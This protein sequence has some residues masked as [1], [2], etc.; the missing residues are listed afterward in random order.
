MSVRN[1]TFDHILPNVHDWP[2]YKI[3]HNRS[4]F[5]QELNEFILEH[6]RDCTFTQL[7]E[8]MTKT[9]YLEK[10]RIKLNPWKVDPADENNYW[11][12]I[13]KELD[14]IKNLPDRDEHGKNL[15]KKII[16]RYN[17]EIV[18][19]FSPRTFLFIRIFLL[20][21]FKRI[22]LRYFG[23]GRWRWGKKSDL[24]EKIKIK[25]NVELIRSL[26]DKG[27]VVVLPTHYSNLDSIMVG[28]A[29]DLNVGLPSF[30][31]GAG[32]NLFNYEIPA[33]FMSRLGAFKVDRRKK[34]P[35]YLECL[36][37]MTTFSLLNGVNCIFFPGG[38]RSRNGA[39]E[40]KL[41]LGL[42]GSL[43]DAQRIMLENN[44]DKKVFVVPLSISYNFVLEGSSL[45]DQHLQL[46]GRENYLRS[47]RRGPVASSIFR[48]LKELYTQESDVYMSFGDPMDVLGNRVD[49][50]GSSIDKKGQAVAVSD[51]FSLEGTIDANAQRESVYA[52]ILGESITE[53]YLH[54][55][56]IL[57]SNV[58]AY[59]AFRCIMDE[60]KETDIISLLSL[61]KQ[62]FIIEEST[63]I[64]QISDI[65]R[66]VKKLAEM[67]YCKLS[68]ENW[69]DMDVIL[70]SGLKK[71]GIYHYTTVLTKTKHA[72]IQC[73]DIKLLYF[74]HNRLVRYNL[75]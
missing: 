41:K 66:Q 20:S 33:F 58:V 23:K 65:V 46:V 75:K 55:T 9:A 64:H 51:Y 63:L 12:T 25:G 3:S 8:M 2:I 5:I 4:Q 49:A 21:F 43:V 60:N 42:I 54:N 73:K 74:Y 34:N 19:K 40:D 11:R 35:I 50:S 10:Q 45:I 48:F 22:F 67:D 30:S 18:G 17:A 32:L 57:N 53:S 70:N 69:E 26:F 16:H 28:Y 61:S 52:K 44:Q 7:H 27:V 36:K 6:Y 31:Y 1:Q 24:Q 39:I 72:Q 29:I 15:L 62:D 13:S 37:S 38:T 14:D 59:A 71:L 68:D 47:A 56:V